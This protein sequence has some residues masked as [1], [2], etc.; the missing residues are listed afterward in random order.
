[1]DGG[2]TEAAALRSES[3]SFTVQAIT[4]V[5]EL[6]S[7][8]LAVIGLQ[9]SASSAFAPAAFDPLIIQPL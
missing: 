4:V 1:M 9:V 8:A 3:L 5:P 2:L 6:A 7:L